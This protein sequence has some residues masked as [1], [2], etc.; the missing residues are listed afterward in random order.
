MTPNQLMLPQF[1]I[2]AQGT[3]AHY[4]LE[5]IA[6]HAVRR[7]GLAHPPADLTIGKQSRPRATC[8]CATVTPLRDGSADGSRRLVR[9][10]PGMKGA[11][12]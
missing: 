2:F 5:M 12:P 7:D 10:P 9:H 1:G 4:F 6:Y 8:Q 11:D 3:H